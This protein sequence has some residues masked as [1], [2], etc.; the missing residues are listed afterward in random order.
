MILMVLTIFKLSMSFTQD[1]LG[2]LRTTQNY[3]GFERGGFEITQ[4]TQE[5]YLALLRSA[6]ITQVTQVGYL[7][8]LGYLE[9]FE[10]YIFS[11]LYAFVDQVNFDDPDPVDDNDLSVHEIR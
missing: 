11:D 9:C 6:Q 2:L 5:T 10:K 7:G 1:Y 4:I 3:L 8:Y